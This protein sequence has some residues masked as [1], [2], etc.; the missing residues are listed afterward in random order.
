VA[1]SSY[2][3]GFCPILTAAWFF[4]QTV[5][6]NPFAY[7]SPVKDSQYFYDLFPARQ[8]S[9]EMPHADS[10]LVKGHSDSSLVS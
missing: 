10:G 8:P 7:L 9:S 2:K 4:W 3:N 1:L 5:W 6:M